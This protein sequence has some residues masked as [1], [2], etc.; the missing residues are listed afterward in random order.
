MNMWE[1]LKRYINIKHNIG[2]I[3]TR[4]DMLWYI[5]NGPPPKTGSY[6][7]GGDGYRRCL[8]KLGILEIVGR[9]Q[10]KIKYYIKENVTSSQ[11]KEIAYSESWKSWFTDI[12]T[13]EKYANKNFN[14]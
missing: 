5:Y 12:K 10:Y 7:T 6:G 9:G 1:R 2:D 13:E 3:I 14:Y 4:Q 8:D 11:I